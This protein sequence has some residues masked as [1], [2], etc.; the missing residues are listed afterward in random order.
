MK[1][2]IPPCIIT[3]LTAEINLDIDFNRASETVKQKVFKACIN[4]WYIIY[5][6][7]VTD[8]SCLNLKYYTHISKF[9]FDVK[10][11][12]MKHD[13]I[14]YYYSKFL[15]LLKNARLIEVND[16][17][18]FNKKSQGKSGKYHTK[19]Y[20]INK[21]LIKNNDLTPIEIDLKLLTK[22]TRNK[23]YWLKLYPQY[24]ELIKDC[25]RTKVELVSYLNWLK[26]NSG[27]VLDRK[28]VTKK[29]TI[30]GKEVE[31]SVIENR[32]L[33]TER[34]M[35]Y[36][37]SVIKHNMGNLWF[38]VTPEGRFYTSL[39]NLSSTAIPYLLLNKRHLRSI[40]ISN[41]QPLLLASLIS[42]EQYKADCGNG[43]FYQQIMNKLDIDK[44]ETKQLLYKYLFFT[45]KPLQ[46]GKLYKVLDCLYPGL[47]E[48][49]N[50]IKAV[51]SLAHLL[52]E[53]EANIIVEGAGRLDFPKLLRHDQVLMFEENYNDVVDY[54]KSAYRKIG[55]E[56]TFKK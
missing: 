52:Q 31:V 12:T 19:S 17:Y 47:V 43:I 53:M 36:T 56:V 15:E 35:R 1:I 9:D 46:G 16:K 41:S 33:D 10:E 40:D 27:V 51:K 11:F 7:Q 25:Y 5:D 37:N 54:L 14:V 20:R 55:L 24:A 30:K 13:K 39:I 50:A 38:K 42:N 32:I 23:S 22:N 28:P 8:D 48:Q 49:I 21:V 2:N 45:N 6:K 26:E 34:I 44:V 4:L 29:I 3:A 18:R